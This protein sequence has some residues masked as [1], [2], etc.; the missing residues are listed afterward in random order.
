LQSHIDLLRTDFDAAVLDLQGQIDD[1][2][3]SQAAQDVVI[4][5]IQTAAS[6]LQD[7]VAANEGDI[8]ALETANNFQDQLIQALQ[9][10]L[11]ALEARVAANEGDIAAIILADQVT[12]A[13]ILSLQTQINNLN[14]LIAANAGDI[15]SLQSQVGTLIGQVSFL[16]TQL[17]MKQMRV[18]GVCGP[19]SSI[20]VINA[21][22]SVVC[23][24]DNVSAGVGTLDTLTVNSAQEI[25]SAGI[26]VGS[27]NRNTFC[28][29]GYSN[30]GGG[31]E[32]ETFCTGLLCLPGDPRLVKVLR[33]QP[34]TNGYNAFVINDNIVVNILGIISFRSR[35]RVFA[36]CGR[37]L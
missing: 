15:G 5:A 26:F 36:R 1:L 9:T 11:T 37:V 8:A 30:T 32:I 16:Q 7:R 33:T 19:G 35:L 10:D 24:V 2:V 31:F 28:P 12:Q 6:L 29:S 23:E 13:L 22:G 21:N 25:P 18:T 20:R 17:A 4:S 34:F 3:A 27:L 14:L